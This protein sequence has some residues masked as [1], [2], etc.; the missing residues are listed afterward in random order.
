M[1][2]SLSARGKIILSLIL[3][4]VVL[5][6]GVAGY[7]AW[8][9]HTNMADKL[10]QAT[11]LTAKQ[12][13]DINTLENKLQINK[14]NAELTVAAIAKAQNGQLQPVTN[15]IIQATSPDQAAQQVSDKINNNDSSLPPVALE[16]TDRTIVSSITTTTA[17][18]ASID[19][20]NTKDGANIND[21]YL[22]QVYKINNYRNW[23]WSAGYGQH[24]GDR[25][26]PIELQ[27]NYSKD[28]AVSAEYHYGG[29]DTGYE[30]KYTRKT[31]KLFLLF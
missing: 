22:T 29:N 12:A 27:R 11:V 30:V 21:N 2:I 18:K 5:V 28:A 8:Q 10:A 3:I 6:V 23:E 14:Q 26:I 15:F 16:K 4:V 17:Q 9:N 7:F 25:Y 19:K 31:D 1:N 24:G 20:Q 13:T